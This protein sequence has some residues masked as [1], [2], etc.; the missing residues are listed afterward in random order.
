MRLTH[1]NGRTDAAGRA[2]RAAH[3][4]RDFTAG[5][6]RRIDPARTDKNLYFIVTDQ[7]IQEL[8]PGQTFTD[9]ELAF[10]KSNFSDMLEARNE[11][12]RKHRR[13]DRI[14]S[15]EQYYQAGRTCPEETILQVGKAGEL[16]PTDKNIKAFAWTVRDYIETH[17]KMYPEIVFLD[18]AVHVDE[19]SIHAHVRKVY[20]AKNAD[21]NME[22]AQDRCL[23]K[24]GFSLPDPDRPQ[25]RYNNRKMSYTEAS[26]QLWLEICCKHGVR[27]EFLQEPEPG[28]RRG[29][30]LD[31]YRAAA[32]RKKAEAAEAELEKITQERD[33][34]AEVA[35]RASQ[36]AAE[37]L[38]R[39]RAITEREES[40]AAAELVRIKKYM[41]EIGPDGRAILDE[42][43]KQERRRQARDQGL[44][45]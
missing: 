23:E 2:Y 22:A 44:D 9:H 8:P 26:R 11:N 15:I 32:A 24:A 39:L 36:K 19:T 31:D 14:R 20:L 17:M 27:K 42:F 28:S 25:G 12:Y 1:H 10:Y 43:R 34:A 35:A 38:D 5:T 40:T 7:G 45:R 16:P 6:D 21:G 4:D 13:K 41:Q 3:N 18:A 29:M 37:T 30:D 33:R